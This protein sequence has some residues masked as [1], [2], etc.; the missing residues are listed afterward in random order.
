MIATA[1]TN[2]RLAPLSIPAL[3]VRT[4]GHISRLVWLFAFGMVV[5]GAGSVALWIMS[6]DQQPLIH[7]FRWQNSFFLAGL[8]GVE[9][10]MALTCWRL[11]ERGE[12]LGRAWLFIS[13]GSGFRL[14]GLVSANFLSGFAS[15]APSP[16]GATA[17]ADAVEVVSLGVL[18][19]LA[20]ALL[21][22]GLFL[23]L[24]AYRDVGLLRRPGPAGMI[25]LVAVSAFLVSQW[26]EM[27][28]WWMSLTGPVGV[29]QAFNGVA[30]PLLG[31]LLLEAVLLYCTVT[32]LGDGLIASCWGAYTV[33]IFLTAFGDMGI[34]AMSREIVPAQYAYVN[35][36]VWILAGLAFA[37]GPAYQAEATVRA[38]NPQL[39]IKRW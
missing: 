13:L 27:A 7:F 11:F 14:A 1:T 17:R 19:P 35:S 28:R 3:L 34:W 16:Q 24:R 29:L 8:A 32:H 33:A 36:L 39:G 6:G 12:P 15:E 20:F 22:V 9:W 4:G 2:V 25:L 23:V 18:N 31:I 37:L 5:L 30:H 10:A 26:V 38:R 21:V